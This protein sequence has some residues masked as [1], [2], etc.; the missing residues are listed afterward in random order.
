MQKSLSYHIFAL[1]MLMLVLSGCVIVINQATPEEK[2]LMAIQD[3]VGKQM[4]DVSRKV[5]DPNYSQAQ[6]EDF[7]TQA[8]STI[9]Q[10]LQR[11]QELDVP[12]KTKQFAEQTKKYLA[13]AQEIFVKLKDFVSNVDNLKKMGEEQLQ[14]VG[15][16]I[17]M[18]TGQIN[19]LV[20]Q[21]DQA[22]KQI[23]D[24]YKSIT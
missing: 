6:K 4:T 12:A 9:S 22:R 10:A 5:G 11:I 24:N 20:H 1:S 13:A 14:Q 17:D 23:E 15:K 18:F 19:N 8:E 21:I 2:E 16:T 7:I 3:T